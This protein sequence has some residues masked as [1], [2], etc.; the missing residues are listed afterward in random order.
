MFGILTLLWACGGGHATSDATRADGTTGD[1]AVVVDAAPDASL[2]A[3]PGVV[4]T[5]KAVAVTTDALTKPVYVTQPH[6]STDLYVVEQ[7]GR[8][9]IVRGGHVLATPFLDVTAHVN[10]PFPSAEGGLLSVAFDPT[11]AATGRLFVFITLKAGGGKPDRVAIEEYH[12]STANPDV[13]DPTPVAELIGAPHYGGNNV[14]GTLAFGPD[15]YLWIAIGDGAAMP[16]QA[17]D[18]GARVGKVLRVDVDHPATPP[19]GGLAN[20]N[21][22]I[23]PFI[24]DYGLRN[25]YRFSFDRATGDLYLADAGDTRFEEVDVEAPATGHHDF[26]WDRM[27]GKH[28][29][30][31][32]TSCGAPGTLPAYELAHGASFSVI[33][34]GAVYR[35]P[36]IPCLQGRYVFPIFG[37]GRMLSWEWRGGA[38]ADEVELTD[39]FADVSILM[40]TSVGQ[41]DAGELYLTTI[42]GHLYRIVAA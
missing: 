29:H 27:E 10:L 40:V 9:R 21:P 26:G 32:T 37:A 8:I 2:C 12:R 25:P 14:G 34:G 1:G 17:A 31:G 42:E 18:L 5:L 15:G 24:W 3:T 16:S 30:D 28:C 19:P 11:Y 23:D 7:P 38:V 4:P 41:D 33:V 39:M 35:G 13:A 36:A 22:A 20:G 6:G